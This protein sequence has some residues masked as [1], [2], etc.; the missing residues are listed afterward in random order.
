MHYCDLKQDLLWAKPNMVKYWQSHHEFCFGLKGGDVW[1]FFLRNSICSSGLLSWSLNQPQFYTNNFFFFFLIAPES[2]SWFIIQQWT[3]YFSN[4]GN[5]GAILYLM[6]IFS[7][8]QLRDTKRM[9][10]LARS[11]IYT[12]GCT[13]TYWNKGEVTIRWWMWSSLDIKSNTR[14]SHLAFFSSGIW[15]KGIQVSYGIV[16]TDTEAGCSVVQGLETY[17]LYHSFLMQLQ[18]SV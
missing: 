10:I 7:T 15:L 6:N 14:I 1:G 17:L 3:H 4:R 11:C 9:S 12:H 8:D 5:S 18:K 2:Q 16:C 13:F